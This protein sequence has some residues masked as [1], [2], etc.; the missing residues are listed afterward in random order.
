MVPC[1]QRRSLPVPSQT[2]PALITALVILGIFALMLLSWRSKAKRQSGIRELAALPSPFIVT[3]EFAG[4]YVATTPSGIP[5]QRITV[6]GLG[7]RARTTLQ[8]GDGGFAFVLSGTSP[9]FIP[10]S[11]VLD[12]R[13]ASWTI[14]RGVGSAGLDVIHWTLGDMELDSYFRLDD[15]EGFIEATTRFQQREKE[16]Q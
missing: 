1:A 12:I 6:H 11:D 16:H 7:F 14:D 2:I 9:R 3:H 4:L 5:L 10:A 13:R 8:L 15:S